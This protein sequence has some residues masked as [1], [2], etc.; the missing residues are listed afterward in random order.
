MASIYQRGPYEWQVLI[1]RKG[2]ETQARV[3]NTKAEADAWA[4]VTE[5]EMVRGVFV[6]WK[7]AEN[8]T[9]EEALDRYSQEVSLL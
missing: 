7:E 4:Q 6:S 5:S 9:L 3:F 8:T 1:R 2:F